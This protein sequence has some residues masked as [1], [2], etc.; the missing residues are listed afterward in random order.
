MLYLVEMMDDVYEIL[1]HFADLYLPY[2]TS[3]GNRWRFSYI[4]AVSWETLK[5]RGPTCGAH[6]D[7]EVYCPNNMAKQI[8]NKAL[9]PCSCFERKTIDARLLLSVDYSAKGE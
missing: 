2:I 6:T 1:L 8:S 5:K 9:W 7:S 4:L 3:G